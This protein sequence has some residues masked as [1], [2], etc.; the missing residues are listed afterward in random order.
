VHVKRLLAEPALLDRFAL[1]VV[2][3]GFAY[4]DDIAAGRVL[5]NELR[6][7]LGER[8]LQFIDRGG[9]ALGICNGFQALVR[10]GLLPRMGG[11]LQQ[12]VTL[13]FN[14]SSHYEC[15]WVTLK[16]SKSRCVFVPEGW[17]MHCPAAHGE[18]MLL[19]ANA[20]E[21]ALL[22]EE[23][24]VVFRYVDP[25]G[26]PTESYPSNPNGSPDGIAGLTDVTGRVLG[27]MPHPD[28]AYL[29]WLMPDWRRTGLAKDGEGMAL[30]TA[31]VQA[32]Q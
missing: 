1:F 22:G 7:R 8:L 12:E 25:R 4:G 17:T 30:F 10:L 26:Q 31:M 15:R 6:T 29:P 2:P 20:R 21:R 3:G 32:A 11:A 27:L 18:G 16:S 23:G 19:T 28:R 9:L 5:A 13:T 14:L 24:Y